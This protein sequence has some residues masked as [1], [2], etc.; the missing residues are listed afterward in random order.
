MTCE[1][2]VRLATGLE[3][4]G[5]TFLVE[6]LLSQAVSRP[7]LF[8]CYAP[9]RTPMDSKLIELGCKVVGIDLSEEML[10]LSRAKFPEIELH[11]ADIEKDLSML[12]F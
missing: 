5:K 9:N 4:P 3:P 11:Q 12:H 1:N 8:L 10:K 2:T 7:F 6:N